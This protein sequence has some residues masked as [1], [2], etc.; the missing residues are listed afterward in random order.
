MP[1]GSAITSPR[2]TCWNCSRS[3]PTPTWYGEAG[4]I[5]ERKCGGCHGPGGL[6]PFE[7]VDYD[8][9]RREQAAAREQGRY[10]GI[11][12]STY[13]EICAMGPSTA[14]PAGGWESGTVRVEPTGKVTV[15]LSLAK[16]V[17]VTGALS[18]R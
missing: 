14:M 9:F 5:V 10:L 2:R 8:G 12:F 1:T 18:G 3:T 11:G 15:L 17:I 6:A 4:S 13:V 16:P 7:L